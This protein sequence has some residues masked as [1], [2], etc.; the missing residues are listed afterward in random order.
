MSIFI[1][2]FFFNKNSLFDLFL[3]IKLT[4]IKKRERKT[5][6]LL[7]FFLL[8]RLFFLCVFLTAHLHILNK[9][10]NDKIQ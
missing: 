6:T 2:F 5:I 8:N 4:R 3:H 10:Q 9:K 1:L 7:L